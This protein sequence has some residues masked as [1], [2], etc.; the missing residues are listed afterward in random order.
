M[1]ALLTLLTGCAGLS[2]GATRKVFVDA[3]LKLDRVPEGPAR[4]KVLTMTDAGWVRASDVGIVNA[5]AFVAEL[6]RALVDHTLS[7]DE[8]ARLETLAE[9]F[10][11]ASLKLHEGELLGKR[12]AEADARKIVQA[13]AAGRLRIDGTDVWPGSAD[14]PDR[15]KAIGLTPQNCQRTRESGYQTETCRFADADESVAITFT[16][17]A[18]KAD[19]RLAEKPAP[20]ERGAVA[21]RKS[22]K[23]LKVRSTDQKA[24]SEV[25]RGV[26]TD[27]VRLG[28]IALTDFQR[29]LV[30]Q[31]FTVD[32]CREDRDSYHRDLSCDIR[33]AEAGGFARIRWVEA[34][35]IRP[36][37]LDV[38][39]TDS[40]AQADL[41][42][43][44][45][46]ARLHTTE[47]S[48]VHLE[49]FRNAP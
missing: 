8:V 25:V 46:R 17:F 44:V 40:E 16:V 15:G 7:D 30:A 13:A 28:P 49:R 42:G 37:E 29:T 33:N 22:R 4:T 35:P 48:T 41:E 36:G 43:L 18:D 27:E 11:V 38:T 24:A 2:D 34:Q 31:G 12:Q 32:A 45:V 19:A 3:A 14:L 6:D 9:G 20:W 21:F 5:S 23:V 1:I 47:A 26:L 10:G 39:Y